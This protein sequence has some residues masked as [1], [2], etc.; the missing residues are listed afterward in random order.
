MDKIQKK[1]VWRCRFAESNPLA[2]NV[3]Y[4]NAPSLADALIELHKDLKPS[5]VASYLV[6]ISFLLCEL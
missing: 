3:I 4:V 2:L 1:M 5:F 6:E